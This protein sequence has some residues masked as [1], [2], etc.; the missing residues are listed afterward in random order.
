MK[1]PT[2]LFCS[3][4]LLVLTWQP[5]LAMNGTPAPL[6]IPFAPKSLVQVRVGPTTI[7]LYPVID[8]TMPPHEQAHAFHHINKMALS[9]QHIDLRLWL[10]AL[11]NQLNLSTTVDGTINN[12]F[13]C[14]FDGWFD[15]TRLTILS[16]HNLKGNIIP[17]M[18]D[19]ANLPVL[20]PVVNG[21]LNTCRKANIKYV[22]VQITINFA[23]L[24]N[25]NPPGPTTMCAEYYIKLPQTSRQ[26]LNE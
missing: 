4:S 9:A 24:V 7:N 5:S 14:F 17:D 26:M 21:P 8:Q 10:D 1:K 2:L 13:W 11:S 22:W 3:S 23:T 19:T 16:F 6:G 18:T 12:W 15:F 20:L 25:V